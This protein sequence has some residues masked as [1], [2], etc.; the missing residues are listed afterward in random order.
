MS[1]STSDV[2]IHRLTVITS[3]IV[4]YIATY[5]YLHSSGILNTVTRNR[6]NSNKTMTRSRSNSINNSNSN[7][8]SSIIVTILVLFNGGLLLVDHMH[9]QYNGNMTYANII[10]VSITI[11]Y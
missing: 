8:D 2:Y 6:S 7:V 3:D 5:R 4:L 1:Y 11:H 9:F 10:L